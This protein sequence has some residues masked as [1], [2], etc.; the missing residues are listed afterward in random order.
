MEKIKFGYL[1]ISTLWSYSWVVYCLRSPN[2]ANIFFIQMIPKGFLDFF[3]KASSPADLLFSYCTFSWVTLFW[4]F[5]S[6]KHIS[7]AKWPKILRASKRCLLQSLFFNE[8]KKKSLLWNL[9]V[10]FNNFVS[11]FSFYI[12]I[13]ILS[14]LLW[15]LLSRFNSKNPNFPLSLYHSYFLLILMC[16]I[17]Q[18]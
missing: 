17:I 9:L 5:L 18:S 10:C 12:L 3:V 16:P 15:S 1:K 8:K 7:F 6:H 2:W 4:P 11:L 13:I 14:K